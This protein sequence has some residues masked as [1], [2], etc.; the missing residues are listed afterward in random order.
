MSG[1]DN[2]DG[3]F[4]AGNFD[5]NHFPRAISVVPNQCVLVNN[6]LRNFLGDFPARTKSDD[7][8]ERIYKKV[9]WRRQ[10]IKIFGKAVTSPRLC[11]WHGDQG[12]VYRYSGTINI[13]LPWI[14]ELLEIRGLIEAY[15]RQS[16]NSVLLNLYRDG[17]DSMGRHS[18]DEPELGIAPTIASVSLGATRRFILH[19]NP[20]NKQPR[21]TV[22]LTHGSL[23]VMHGMSQRNWKHS[24]PKTRRA[25]GPR[26]NLTYRWVNPLYRSTPVGA[27]VD[28]GRESLAESAGM[29]AKR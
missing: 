17:N 22:N 2:L 24:L 14:D 10:S 4:D 9:K 18:D 5:I 7:M 23:L 16:F 19:P 20:T 13:P 6:F 15:T 3:D 26:I 25:T 28:V 29:T 21:V 27:V 1:T 8:F 12:A 11:A